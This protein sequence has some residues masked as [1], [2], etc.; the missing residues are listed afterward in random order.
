MKRK[1][2]GHGRGFWKAGIYLSLFIITVKW[3]LIPRRDK[4]KEKTLSNCMRGPK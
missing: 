3:F 2:K 1:K 4:Y